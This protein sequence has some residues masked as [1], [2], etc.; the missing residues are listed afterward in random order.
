MSNLF[1]FEPYPQFGEADLIA[2]PH[3][4]EWVLRPTE[5]NRRFWN[6]FVERYPAKQEEVENGRLFLERLSFREEVP[7]AD[8]VE[9][10]LQQ[11]LAAIDG[12]EAGR[13]V[14]LPRRRWTGLLKA[15][16]LLAGAVLILSLLLLRNRKETVETAYGVLKTVTLPDRSTVV[17]NAHSKIEYRKKWKEG[18]PREIWLEGEAF[19]DVTHL[20]RDARAVRPGERFVVHTGDLDVEVLG[21]SFNV[22]QRRGKTEVVLQEGSVK[23]AFRDKTHKDVLMKP[24]ERVAYAAGAQRLEQGTANPENYTAWKEK[25]LILTNPTVTEITRYLE[26]V[27][28]RKIMLEAPAMGSTTI[29]GPLLLNNLDDVLFIL[30]TVLN[31]E[32]VRT[33]STVTLRPR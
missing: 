23:L 5:E 1:N 30:S 3:F 19:F 11:H 8:R 14:A 6:A 16:A 21:T 33:D 7:A 10:L 25:K 28:G 17:L 2:D 4:Q 32:V 24:G 29:E 22:R 20:N 27:Y 18:A 9:A 26:D 13:V 31:A 15:A 12:L